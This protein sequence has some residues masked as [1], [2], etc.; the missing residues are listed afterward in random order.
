MHGLH[1]T[2]NLNHIYVRYARRPLR[3][4]TDPIGLFIFLLILAGLGLGFV[5]WISNEG[6]DTDG[7]GVVGV[8]SEIP[9]YPDPYPPFG[10]TS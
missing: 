4:R 2:S 7:R 5:P 10:N 8:V 3:L 6:M 9:H 1:Q